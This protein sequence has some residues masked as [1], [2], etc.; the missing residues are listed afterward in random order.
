MHANFP[1]R[2]PAACCA[3]ALVV[4]ATQPAAAVLVLAA[5]PAAAAR[6]LTRALPRL[7]ILVLASGIVTK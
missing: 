4:L 2:N 3:Y 6:L 5:H 1:H 7:P